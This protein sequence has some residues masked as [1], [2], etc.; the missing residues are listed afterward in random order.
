MTVSL[1]ILRRVL[2]GKVK[3]EKIATG[4][5]ALGGLAFDGAICYIFKVRYHLDNVG[6]IEK[7]HREYS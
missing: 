2:T 1:I 7:C 3:S 5:A 6:E 4:V